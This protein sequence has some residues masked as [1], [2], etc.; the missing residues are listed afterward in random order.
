MRKNFLCYRLHGRLGSLGRLGCSPSVDRLFKLPC[1]LPPLSLSSYSLF[2]YLI[3]FFFYF[4]FSFLPSFFLSFLPSLLLSLSLFQSG[5]KS[6]RDGRPSVSSLLLK[7]SWSLQLPPP[8][9]PH[10]LP[11]L[12]RR[13][14]LHL[15][16][17]RKLP[18]ATSVPNLCQNAVS[19]CHSH[20]QAQRRRS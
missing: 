2:F 8:H 20:H 17:R 5:L 16:P 15:L 19:R 13:K 7:T 12:P 4:F 10:P 9:P 11:L 3:F 18:L 14:L 1:C 6:A